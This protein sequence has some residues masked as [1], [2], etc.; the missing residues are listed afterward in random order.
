M[1]TDIILTKEQRKQLN[2]ANCRCCLLGLR[3]C[4]SCK[5]NF[6][7]KVIEAEKIERL[8][9]IKKYSGLSSRQ[10]LDFCSDMIEPGLMNIIVKDTFG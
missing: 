10:I 7:L 2:I 8:E 4:K 9:N 6:A 1:S 3:D 5:F